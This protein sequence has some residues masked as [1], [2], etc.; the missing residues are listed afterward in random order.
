MSTSHAPPPQLSVCIPTYK[1]PAL[2]GIALRAV[3]AQITPALA[4]AV[5]VVVLDNASPDDTPAVVRGAQEDFAHVPLRYVRHAENIGP[6]ANFFDAV[7]QARGEFVYLLSDDDILQP[8]AV[9]RLLA[10]IREH[11]GLDAFCLNIRHFLSDPALDSGPLRI[12]EIPEDRV[13]PGR[14]EALAFLKSHITF[15]SAIVF[16]RETVAGR[17]YRAWDGTVISHAF[18][19]VDALAPDNGMYVTS[20]VYLAQ[21]AENVGGYNFFKVFVTDF[22]AL[23]L[24]AERAGYARWA[25]RRVLAHHLQ[26]LRGFIVIF[27]VRGAYGQIRPDYQDGIARMWRAYGPRPF[28]LIV[29]LPLMLV[30]RP[31]V[32][33]ARA[34]V[35]GLRAVIIRRPPPSSLADPR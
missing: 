32:V 1:R 9:A 4:S 23:L 19:F 12:F 18:F 8:G 35:R 13:L 16:R 31:L 24:Y 2:L 29:L 20:Q 27:K 33:L 26:V 3:L 28:F 11:P 34:L 17:D 22:Q 21:R 5:E 30:P 14:D 7:R 15:I 6:D 25:V 10:L